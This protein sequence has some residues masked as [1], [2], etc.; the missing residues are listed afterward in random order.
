MLCAIFLVR[1]CSLCYIGQRRKDLISRATAVLTDGQGREMTLQLWSSLASEEVVRKLREGAVGTASMAATV[2]TTGSTAQHGK[3]SLLDY[4]ASRRGAGREAVVF[5]FTQLRPEFSF[6]CETL[7]LNTTRGSEIRTLSPSS[8]EACTIANTAVSSTRAPATLPMMGGVALRTCGEDS[9]RSQQEE[10]EYLMAANTSPARYFDSV[11]DLIMTDGFCGKACV[12]CVVVR[13]VETPRCAASQDTIGQTEFRC[14]I[15]SAIVYLGDS[16][17]ASNTGRRGG[18]EAVIRVFLDG[19]ALREFL[20]GI[21][22]DFFADAS[23]RKFVCDGKGETGRR[24]T[25]SCHGHGKSGDVGVR[26]AVTAVACSLLDG[27]E[28]G[29]EEGELFDVV[30]ACVASADENGRVVRGGTLYRLIELHASSL[31]ALI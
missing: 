12:K 2:G 6:V 13:K 17:G 30:L 19:E 9:K 26:K 14:P 20:G 18:V 7:V 24:S 29:G 31:L 23:D 15:G 11:S 10:N 3:Q 28:K 5:E 1:A 4:S 22:E 27:L 25:C 21:C 8:P 16:A